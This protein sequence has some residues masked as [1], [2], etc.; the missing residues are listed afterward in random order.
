MNP[1]VSMCWHF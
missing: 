1:Y